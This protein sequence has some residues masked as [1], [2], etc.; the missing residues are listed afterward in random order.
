MNKIISSYKDELIKSDYKLIYPNKLKLAVKISAGN[1]FLFTEK[2]KYTKGVTK[3]QSLLNYN[4]L[5]LPEDSDRFIKEF[6]N[7]SNKFLVKLFTGGRFTAEFPFD[8]IKVCSEDGDN[9]KSIYSKRIK[10]I[11]LNFKTKTIIIVIDKKFNT[12]KEKAWI[13]KNKKAEEEKEDLAKR[14]ETLF[15]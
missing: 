12:R 2:A 1:T 10:E 11:Y 3:F 13:K 7:Y 6:N 8:K 5:F 9:K 14:L 15:K 4:K